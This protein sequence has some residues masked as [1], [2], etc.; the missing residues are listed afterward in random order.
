MG[1]LPM[2]AS[3][4]SYN[5]GVNAFDGFDYGIGSLGMGM[6]GAI[7]GLFT[8]GLWS[9]GQPV[10]DPSNPHAFQGWQ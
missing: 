1:G 7:S 4:Y 6:E 10:P 3:A 8:D 9:F 2:D 5:G